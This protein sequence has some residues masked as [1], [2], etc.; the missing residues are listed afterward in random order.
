[1]MR[2][3]ATSMTALLLASCGLKPEPANLA[4]VQLSPAE[5]TV[6][7]DSLRKTM[8]DPD[9][10]RFGTMNSGRYADGKVVVCGWINAKN[11]GDE[12]FYGVLTTVD[13]KPVFNVQLFGSDQTS[14]AEADQICR[15][16]GGGLPAR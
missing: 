14:V 6:V 15:R 12:P 5:T 9:S 3:I 16:S 7:Q 2:G 11:T 10:V 1:M 8:I 13:G 4:L